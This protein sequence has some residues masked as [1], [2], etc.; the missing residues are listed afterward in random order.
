MI[1]KYGIWVTIPLIAVLLIWGW[2]S[3]NDANIFP[4][5]NIEIKATFKHIDPLTLQR[6]IEPFAAKGFFGFSA[7]E[8]KKELVQEPW[9]ASVD[10]SRVWPDKIIVQ[11]TEKTPLAIWN[12]KSVLADDLEIFTPNKETLPDDVPNFFAANQDQVQKIVDTYSKLMSKLSVLGLHITELSLSTRGSWS[13][14]LS[15]GIEVTLGNEDVFEHFALF[16]AEYNKVFEPKID[17]I[18]SVDFRYNKGFAVK[19]KSQ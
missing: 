5:K 6:I 11:V 10:I 1:K 9:V 19:W 18:K 2:F 15:N 4:L 3:L 16:L 7:K 17:Q 12:G 13:F 8:V 14:R